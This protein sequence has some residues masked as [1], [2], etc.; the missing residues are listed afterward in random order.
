[1]EQSINERIKQ[2]CDYYF[3]GN[4]SAMSRTVL[5]KQSTIRDIIGTKQSKPSFETLKAIVDCPT[6][7][8]SADWLLMGTGNVFD[9]S[10]GYFYFD[11]ENVD[12]YSGYIKEPPKST[13]TQPTLENT[14]S[15][16]VNYKLV[17]L[18]N[19]D[20][21]GGIHSPNIVSEDIEYPEQLI[22]FTDAQEGDVALTVSGESMSP[23]CPPGS[24]VLIRQVPQWKEY[25]GYGNI[26]VLLLTDGRRILKEVQKYQEDPKNFVLCKS[27]NDKYPEEEL[28]KSMISSVWKVVKILNERGW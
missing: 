22:P 13:S 18:L 20:A 9:K 1:M 21:V 26:F 15:N 28:P 2:I 24:R 14:E 19:L 16:T 12:P 7:K 17:P 11:F 5:V 23:T 4:T 3:A 8:V 10:K 6:I 27:H 25:L